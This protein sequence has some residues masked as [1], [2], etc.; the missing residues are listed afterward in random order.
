M[1]NQCIDLIAVDI[2]YGMSYESNLSSTFNRHEAIVNDD[3]VFFPYS[4]LRRILKDDGAMFVFFSHKFPLGEFMLKEQLD[5]AAEMI[6]ARI[7]SMP[8]TEPDDIRDFSA[9]IARSEIDKLMK[10]TTPIVNEIIWYKNGAQSAGD[11]EGDFGN[12]YEKIAFIPMPGFKLKGKRIGNVW[13][14]SRT[15]NEYHPTEKPID[16]MK[17]IVSQCKPGGVVLDPCC[18]S[19][20]TGVACAELGIDYILCEINPSYWPTIE[21]RIHEV[22]SQET[23]F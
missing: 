13:N 18:G 5:G 23:L 8:H 17:V 3:K 19:G 11:L 10:Y 2:P 1:P 21:N 6:A 16:L 15:R 20:A 12:M 9:K 22:K 7:N 4:E 14:Y